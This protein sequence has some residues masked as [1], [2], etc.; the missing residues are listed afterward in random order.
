M[1][2][3]AL[4]VN[5]GAT[6][7]ENSPKLLLAAG[8]LGVGAT[9]YL[10][11]KATLK[12]EKVMDEAAKQREQ[13]ETYQPKDEETYTE[14]DRANDIKIHTMKTRLQMVK[15]YAPA[16]LIGITS[17]TLILIGFKVLNGRYLAVTAAYGTLEKAYEAYRRRI[18]E[19]GGADLDRYGRTGIWKERIETEKVVGKDEDGNDITEKVT[20]ERNVMLDTKQK[21]PFYHK[22]GPG[23]YI[24]D[25]FGGNM[26]LINDAIK[27]I[28]G[29]ADRRYK[30][31]DV[32]HLNEACISEIFGPDSEKLDD[33]GQL[34]G[35]CKYDEKAEAE[36]D[37]CVDFRFDTVWDD[38][39]DGTKKI[40]YGVIDPNCT[41]ISYA[42][43]NKRKNYLPV[44]RT[45]IRTGGKYL[46]NV[47]G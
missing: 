41:Q 40:L 3:H 8:I 27:V 5:A 18:I 44:T 6:L 22:I 16:A 34:C 37:H 13:I 9:I 10:A 11:C 32:V 25:K 31:G 47:G 26:E 28:Q 39:L 19:K 45:R 42:N 24:Y 46:S 1:S 38:S 43:I 4:M 20:E 17:I 12:I 15:T 2:M 33:I 29:N 35:W 21:S 7:S 14:A 30:M 36:G 23:D